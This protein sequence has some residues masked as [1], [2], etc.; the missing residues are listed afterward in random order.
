MRVVRQF[1]R[2]GIVGFSNT[3][4]SYIVYFIALFVLRKCGWFS[5]IDYLV[6]QIMM[7]I[8]GVMWS[9]FWNR[10]YVFQIQAGGKGSILKSLVKTYIMYSF[11]GLFLSGILLIM[12]VQVFH[13]SEFIAPVINLAVT[14][15]LNFVLAKVWA[16]K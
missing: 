13:I 8:V 7:F 16:F 15:P 6:A 10:R 12:W 9:F 11:T 1:I 3:I 4:L 14:V 2:F 5:S